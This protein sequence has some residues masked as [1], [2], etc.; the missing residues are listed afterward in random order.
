MFSLDVSVTFVFREHRIRG[1]HGM[2]GQADW[3]HLQSTEI[4]IESHSI[5]IFKKYN[6]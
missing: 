2:G 3:V 4:V 5:F 1:M 6:L